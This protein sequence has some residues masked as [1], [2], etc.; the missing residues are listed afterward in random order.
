VNSLRRL[1]ADAV[2]QHALVGA[3]VAI[4]Q[5]GRPLAAEAGVTDLTGDRPVTRRT[6]FEIG[7]VTKPLVATA[8]LLAEGA[9]LVDLAA[10][11]GEV[12]PEWRAAGGPAV[13]G[14]QLLSHT[15]GLAGDYFPDTGAGPDCLARYASLL[16]AQPVDLPPGTAVSYSNGGYV[17]AGRLLECAA[18]APFDEA[19]ERLV[20]VP[21]GADDVLTWN[22]SAA[23]TDLA[24]GHQL[25]N[26][27]VVRTERRFPRALT[28]AG[29]VLSSALALAQ[30]VRN[31]VLDQAVTP[32]LPG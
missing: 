15:S 23:G 32:N 21:A 24:M 7:S 6:L 14:R 19:L 26:G 16:A 27:Q 8:L 10:P 30:L 25:R 29:G 31:L 12:V 17:L 22:H 9:G 5:A 1:L 28:P 11:V 3:Q 13:T 4:L 20:L 2:E 18:A